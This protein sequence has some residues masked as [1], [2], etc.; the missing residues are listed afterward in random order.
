M[1][2]ENLNTL[3]PNKSVRR[4]RTIQQRDIEIKFWKDKVKYLAPN[5]VCEYYKEIDELLKKEGYLI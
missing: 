4:L 2:N 1:E 3:H 5:L